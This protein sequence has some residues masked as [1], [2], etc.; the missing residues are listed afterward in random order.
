M[1][2]AHPAGALPMRPTRTLSFRAHADVLRRQF[3]EGGGFPITDVLTDEVLADALAAAGRWLDRVFSPLPW[4]PPAGGST[5]S[6]PRWS[7]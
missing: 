2:L 4:P 1:E 5:A 7:P 6:S 3:L